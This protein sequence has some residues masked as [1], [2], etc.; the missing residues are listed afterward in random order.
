M[1]VIWM[2]SV[3]INFTPSF[4]RNSWLENLEHFSPTFF[5]LDKVFEKKELTTFN[6]NSH[7]FIEVYD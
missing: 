1:S 2:P 5:I 7:S 3:T 6:Q 4:Y